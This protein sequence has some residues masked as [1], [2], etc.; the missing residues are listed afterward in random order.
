[1]IEGGPQSILNATEQALYE[2]FMQKEENAGMLPE[3]FKELRDLALHGSR[4]SGMKKFFAVNGII[5]EEK[6]LPSA[7]EIKDAHL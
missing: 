2:K 4:S 7:E 3:D 1:M 5:M 6:D